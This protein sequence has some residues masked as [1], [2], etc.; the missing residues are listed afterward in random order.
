MPLTSI[1]LQNFK[2]FKDSGEI[3][4]RRLTVVFGRNNTGK[5]AILQSLLILRQTMDAPADVARLNLRGPSYDGGTYHD[6]VHNHQTSQNVVFHLA[7]I[8]G[9]TGREGRL[10]LEFKSDE[11][12]APRLSRL[13]ISAP[14]TEQFVI[15]PGRGAGGPYELWI[16]DENLRGGKKA[17][18]RF[19]VNQF[20]P[21]IGEEPSHVGR[22]S[23][24]RKKSR[25]LARQVLWV[26]EESLRS[27][28]A[29]G[30]FRRQPDRRYEY[31]GRPP[32]TVDTTGQHV[33]DALVEDANRRRRHRGELVR[34]V[35]KCLE[36]LGRV[37]LMPIRAMTR[38][39][40]IYEIRLKDTDSGR[41]ANFADVGFGIGQALPV[42]VEGL[43]TPENGTFLVQ[44]P[45][46]HLHPDA[47]LAM[48]DFLIDLVRS[49]RQVVV[50]TH[51]ENILLRIRHAVVQHTSAGSGAKTGLSENDISI[52]HVSKT[53]DAASHTTLLDLD[54]LGQI[55]K[56]PDGFMDEA[57]EERMTIMQEMAR[58]A[59]RK[60]NG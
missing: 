22:P 46:I 13:A 1:R 48:A 36:K 59:A 25:T 42:I 31:Q 54:E 21:M 20:L 55:K 56:W 27:T 37:R 60:N 9:G 3:P 24:R 11:P 53:P 49:N 2:A 41:W 57:T 50:E 5:S 6:V 14:L 34:S 40:K 33:I 4:L 8:Y 23:D 39:T 12:Q 44:E 19:S 16:G 47:Q 58:A 29:V 28:R 7:V 32:Q 51:S 38:Q 15:S 18:F 17:N 10:E 43:R 52:V 26:V 35:N 30:A 45:E